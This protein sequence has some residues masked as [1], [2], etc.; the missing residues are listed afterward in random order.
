MKFKPVQPVFQLYLNDAALK[1]GRAGKMDGYVMQRNGDPGGLERASLTA[2]RSLHTASQTPFA[3][4][5]ACKSLTVFRAHFLTF[6]LLI[7]RGERQ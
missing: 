5:A 3:Q 7:F 1:N 2:S 6:A 4:C